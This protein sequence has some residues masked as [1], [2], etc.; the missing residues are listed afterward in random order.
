[1]DSAAGALDNIVFPNDLPDTVPSEAC[2]SRHNVAQ[3]TGYSTH[4]ERVPHCVDGKV[5]FQGGGHS[6]HS[7]NVLDAMLL[8]EHSG[9][10]SKL[11]AHIPDRQ[12]LAISISHLIFMD[13]LY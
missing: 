3:S 10:Y 8:P 4:Y 11:A 13:H 1:M 6:Q 12:V 7:K 5:H 9:N 2:R